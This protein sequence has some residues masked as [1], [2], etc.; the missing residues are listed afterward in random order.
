MYW[1]VLSPRSVTERQNGL[2]VYVVLALWHLCSTAVH[3]CWRHR[4]IEG[5]KRWLRKQNAHPVSPQ[6]KEPEIPEK[7]REELRFH[8]GQFHSEVLPAITGQ[9]ERGNQ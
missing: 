8:H 2:V 5:R 6:R 9:K 1:K 4:A 3:T 7:T